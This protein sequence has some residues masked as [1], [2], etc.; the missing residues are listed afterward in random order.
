MTNR[1]G[2]R[3]A[4]R[5]AARSVHLPRTRRR[6]AQPIVLVVPHQPT[7]AARAASAVGSW[8]WDTRATWAPTGIALAALPATAIGH[9]AFWWAGF[10]LAPLAAS[11]LGWLAWTG[12]RRPTTDRTVRR[13]RRGLAVVGTAAS[14]WTALAVAFGPLTGPLGLIW[15]LT[16]VA[17]QVLWLRTRR[18]STD[19]IEEIV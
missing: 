2:P 7:L 12:Q 19:P 1:T 15:L 11:P 10:L 14:T 9:A 3:K 17:A 8:L 4:R 6:D 16:T 18:T 13:W 5:G